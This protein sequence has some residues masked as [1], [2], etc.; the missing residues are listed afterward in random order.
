MRR[1]P[2]TPLSL[3]HVVDEHLSA[4]Q[5]KLVVAQVQHERLVAASDPT[6][7]LAIGKRLGDALSGPRS[8]QTQGIPLNI[9]AVGVTQE[10]PAPVNLTA[11]QYSTEARDW[12]A[13]VAP[14]FFSLE[15]TAYRSW[16]EFRERFERLVGAVADVLTPALV[17]RSGL[18]YVDELKARGGLAPADW[19]GTIRPAFLG[20]V[21]D[22]DIGQSVTGLQQAVEFLGPGSARITLRHGTVTTSDKTRAYLLDHDSYSNDSRRFHAGELLKD[23]DGLHRLALGI[24]QLVITPGYYKQLKEAATTP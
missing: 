16:P 8:T 2:V 22:P 18:R 23:Y 13:T 20:P 11:W 12:V 17:Q 24:F 5:L 4:V 10:G 15:T 7:A 14:D 21:S 19:A 1:T 6:V 9:G 3:K